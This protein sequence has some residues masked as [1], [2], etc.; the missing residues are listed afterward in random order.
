MNRLLL[1]FLLVG[2]IPSFAQKWYSDYQDQNKYGIVAYENGS[3]QPIDTIIP[4]KYDYIHNLNSFGNSS[5]GFLLVNQKID[6][7]HYKEVTLVDSALRKINAFEEIL[8]LEGSIAVIKIEGKEQ[9]FDLKANRTIGPAADSISILKAC[10]PFEMNDNYSMSGAECKDWT[11][12]FS[13]AHQGKWTVYDEHLKELFTSKNAVSFDKKYNLLI[14]G[15]TYYLTSGQ[16]I[17]DEIS[18]IEELSKLDQWSAK[19]VYLRFN[20][21]NGKW[22]LCSGKQVVGRYGKVSYGPEK[23]IELIDL[24]NN[25]TFH[26]NQVLEDLYIFSTPDGYEILNSSREPIELGTLEDLLI[27]SEHHHDILMVKKNDRFYAIDKKGDQISGFDWDQIKRITDPYDYDQYFLATKDQS[28]YLLDASGKKVFDGAIKNAIVSSELYH[29]NLTL[30]DQNDQYAFRKSDGSFTHFG[31]ATVER[32]DTTTDGD[33]VEIFH[34]KGSD[35]TAY[36]RLYGDLLVSEFKTNGNKRTFIDYH[37]NGLKKVEGNLIKTTDTSFLSSYSSSWIPFEY[38]TEYNEIGDTIKHSIYDPS[39]PKKYFREYEPLSPKSYTE[40]DFVHDENGNKVL[41]YKKQFEFSDQLDFYEAMIPIGWEIIRNFDGV[42][43]RKTFYEKCKNQLQES[44]M[45][46]WGDYPYHSYPSKSIEYHSNGQFHSEF[47]IGE[48]SISGTYFDS[49]GNILA[50]HKVSIENAIERGKYEWDESFYYVNDKEHIQLGTNDRASFYDNGRVKAIAKHDE[51]DNLVKEIFYNQNGKVTKERDPEQVKLYDHDGSYLTTYPFSLEPLNFNYGTDFLNAFVVLPKGTKVK[52]TKIQY[53]TNEHLDTL[54]FYQGKLSAFKQYDF[55]V[56]TLLK[57]SYDFSSNEGYELFYLN[58][59]GSFKHY[60]TISPDKETYK[61]YMDSKLRKEQLINK[62]GELYTYQYDTLGSIEKVDSLGFEI[63]SSYFHSNTKSILKS[64]TISYQRKKLYEYEFESSEC[65]A[66]SIEQYQ[67]RETSYDTITGISSTINIEKS[68]WN[69]SDTTITTY[70]TKNGNY[71][72]VLEERTYSENRLI[73]REKY[74]DQYNTHDTLLIEYSIDSDEILELITLDLNKKM[75]WHI[76]PG[77]DTISY[78]INCEENFVDAKDF[79]WSRYSSI[80][81]KNCTR[82]SSHKSYYDNGQLTFEIYGDS[83]F[84]IYYPNGQLASDDYELNLDA[85]AG[86]QGQSIYGFDFKYGVFGEGKNLKLSEHVKLMIPKKPDFKSIGGQPTDKYLLLGKGAIYDKKQNKTIHYLGEEAKSTS[87][88]DGVQY[89]NRV[90]DNPMYLKGGVN[91]NV[92]YH[93]ISDHYQKNNYRNT[94]SFCANVTPDGKYLVE[95]MIDEYNP[96]HPDQLVLLMEALPLRDTVK[97]ISIDTTGYFLETLEDARIEFLDDDRIY[98]S[99]F[100]NLNVFSISQQKFIDSIDWE[101]YHDHIKLTQHYVWIDSLLVNE[102]I[103]DIKIETADHQIL[104][105]KDSRLVPNEIISA[106]Y[107]QNDQIALFRNYDDHLLR[108]DHLT[109]KL[110]TLAKD[111]LY[112]CEWGKAIN[113]LD[114]I[115]MVDKD[116]PKRI[117]PFKK[118]TVSLVFAPVKIKNIDFDANAINFNH[119]QIQTPLAGLNSKSENYDPAT[120]LD[121]RWEASFINKEIIESAN[122]IHEQ[123]GKL[124]Y[125]PEDSSSIYFYNANKKERLERHIELFPFDGDQ[126][127]F[128]SPEHYYAMSSDIGERMYYVKDL[129]PYPLEQFDLK[130]NRPDIILDRLGYA[131]SSLVAA[132]HHAYLKRLKKMGFSEDMLEDDFHL[133]E[134]KINNYHQLPSLA[135]TTAL[136]LNLHLEDGKYPLDRINVWVNDV[137]IYGSKGISIRDLNAK[138]IDKKVT[139]PLSF[140]SNKIQ[141]S[142]LNQAGAES[143]KETFEITCSKGKKQPDLYLIAIGESQFQQNNF[144]LTYAAKDAQDIAKLFSKSKVY[145]QIFTKTLTNQQ[146]TKGNVLALKSFLKNADINDQVI[147]F[148]AGHGVLSADLDYYLATYD[149]DFQSPEGKGLLYEDLESLLDGIQPLKKT[150]IL[151]ACHSGEIDKEEMELA[152]AENTAEGDVQFRA[153]GASVK[154]KLGAQNTLELTK[155]LFTDLR[156]GTGATV[157][158]SAGG[159]EFAMES[160]E[161]KNGLFTYV[162][163]NGIQSGKADLNGDQEIWL[164]ELQ[165]Y[166]SNEVVRLSKGKQQPTSRIENQMVDF[167]IW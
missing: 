33:Y 4:A 55:D 127:L 58:D 152:V 122:N 52:K 47:I 1:C 70:R 93:F 115:Q 84:N 110:D 41:V 149:M 108:F 130:Y 167:R 73:R 113:D 29:T 106:H 5:V 118:D 26:K 145:N 72:G 120:P 91:S 36:Q 138:N 87:T 13:V 23:K 31:S 50:K 101:L 100:R 82:F 38:M 131:D 112:I 76:T 128:L 146:V 62:N 74:P 37:E 150:L 153:V 89:F 158:S 43:T 98:I 22:I 71:V 162:L 143:Y 46:N 16:K 2:T 25:Y 141:V 159:M 81:N 160:G 119:G 63:Y 90:A 85:K 125:V 75:I 9:L 32:T 57:R 133:P 61:L 121:I 27:N 123:E 40:Y 39:N 103:I 28:S 109:K 66:T 54:F 8:D 42:L 11:P 142:V 12:Y 64:R 126:Y 83:I 24:P 78:T 21:A 56:D 96:S 88:I 18:S 155:S 124:I 137:A 147:I 154:N 107:Y 49:L 97:K 104:S 129:K 10:I 117:K 35:I 17:G 132:Y 166:L 68:Q 51:Q 77:T 59:P 3:Y 20:L 34:F 134:I 140:G 102:E 136:E 86:W 116:H 135:D 95:L 19:N 80:F 65:L 99:L 148:V 45:E 161:W 156:K 30:I 69:S 164:S 7:K 79:Y 44:L 14:S 157:I 60:Q 105:I 53:L 144:N 163:L 67:K 139:V 151:D 111:V 15:D 165:I 92:P 114:I 48:E 94:S 6:Y